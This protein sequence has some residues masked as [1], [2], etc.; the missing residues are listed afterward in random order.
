MMEE[1]EY[2]VLVLGIGVVCWVL[3]IEY[4][5]AHPD[6]KNV[7]KG[8]LLA[9]YGK[10]NRIVKDPKTQTPFV[11]I[12]SPV[13][14]TKTAFPVTKIAFLVTKTIVLVTKTTLLVTKTALLV[15]KTA[16]PV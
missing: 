14:I 3:S 9:S 11:V 13:L 2:W 6:K 8:T 10:N 12:K 7:D 4:S 15:T 1:E 5:V 16:L